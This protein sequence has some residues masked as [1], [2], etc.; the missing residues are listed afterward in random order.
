ML[1]LDGTV[2][3]AVTMSENVLGMMSGAVLQRPQPTTTETSVQQEPARVTTEQES[4]TKGRRRRR[5]GRRS[6]RW[7]TIGYRVSNR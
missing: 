5:G 3:G 2:R 1:S 7:D 6:F 4:A